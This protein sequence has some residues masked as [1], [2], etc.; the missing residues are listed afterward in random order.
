MLYVKQFRLMVRE[1][2]QAVG[3]WH[4]AIENLLVGTALQESNLYYLKQVGGP[5]LGFYQIEPATYAWI[6]EKIKEHILCRNIIAKCNLACIPEDPD[7]LGWHLRFAIIV[8][9]F[10]YLVIPDPLPLADDLEGLARYWKRFYNTANGDGTARQF[11]ENY[12][13]HNQSA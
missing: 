3:L 7:I 12:M 5:A 13:K 6:K 1:A 8:A 4:V 2:L 10:R 9:R 11:M